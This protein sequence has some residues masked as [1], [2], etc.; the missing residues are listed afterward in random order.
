M[1]PEQKR[2]FYRD[3]YLI[4]RDI[5][6]KEKYLK[7]ARTIYRDLNAVWNQSMA[8]GRRL[9]FGQKDPPQEMQDMWLDSVKKGMRTGVDPAIL[10]LFAP[11]DPL[12]QSIE[13]ALGGPL[14]ST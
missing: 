2:D 8:L 4:F 9:S 12:R 1:T 14:T 10:D 3:G 6:P 13:E 5:V 7:A 11:E